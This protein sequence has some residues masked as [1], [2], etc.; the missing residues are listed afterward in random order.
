MNFRRAKVCSINLIVFYNNI[1]VLNYVI[2]STRE[3]VR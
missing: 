2:G 1:S 3:G